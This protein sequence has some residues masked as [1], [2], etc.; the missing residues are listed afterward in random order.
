MNRYPETGALFWK[1][2]CRPFAVLRRRVVGC[3]DCI[4]QPALMHAEGVHDGASGDGCM[5]RLPPLPLHYGVGSLVR[6]AMDMCDSSNGEDRVNEMIAELSI[7][8]NRRPR[9]G[10]RPVCPGLSLDGSSNG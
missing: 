7:D 2:T 3:I 5:L 6:L 4:L 1:S 10:L 8:V 9:G